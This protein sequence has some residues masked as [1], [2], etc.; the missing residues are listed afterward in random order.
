MQLDDSQMDALLT[1]HALSPE[2]LRRD[3]FDE[4]LEDRRRRLS[5]LIERVMGKYQWT[6]VRSRIEASAAW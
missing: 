4:F 2:L 6:E 5:G 3:A 1:S